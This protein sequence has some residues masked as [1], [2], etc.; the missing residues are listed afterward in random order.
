MPFKIERK[1]DRN[2]NERF[3]RTDIPVSFKNLE[4]IVKKIYKGIK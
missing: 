1:R 3:K 2:K 4:R